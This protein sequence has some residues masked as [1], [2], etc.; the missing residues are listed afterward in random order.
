MKKGSIYGSLLGR[1]GRIFWKIESKDLSQRKQE[2]TEY[3][4]IQIE[5][6]Q[7]IIE[8]VENGLLLDEHLD[9]INNSLLNLESDKLHSIRKEKEEN[10]YTCVEACFLRIKCLI[11]EAKLR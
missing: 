3:N 6:L 2:L 10:L 8:D 7:K 11:I 4:D 5:R 9:T 1:I